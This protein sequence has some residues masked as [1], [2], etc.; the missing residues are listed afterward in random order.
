MTYSD[1]PV[2][3][4]EWVRLEPLSIAHH[5]DLVEAVLPGE[6]WTTWYTTIP[7]PESMA[8][9]I[10]AR[11]AKHAAGLVAPWAVIDRG[12]GRAV[13]MTTYLNLAPS[14]R[15]L[16]IGSTWLGRA[17]HGTKVNPAAKLLLFQRAF[18]T[19]DTVRV[20]I[21]T[22]F[23]NHQS[24]AAIE[25]L[26]AKLDGVL[27]RHMVLPNGSIRDTCVYSVLDYEWENVRLGLEARL[28]R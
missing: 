11:L 15:R 6:L 26:G 24:R 5:D 23:Q 10:E 27:R 7:S 4:N 18:E 28:A 9:E 2:L 21:R 20:E 13:G 8:G 14:D 17:A 1:A 12:T 22:H 3:E 16:E 25:R 19:L